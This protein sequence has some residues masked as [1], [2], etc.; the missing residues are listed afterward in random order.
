MASEGA[1]G[2]VVR[3]KVASGF[4]ADHFG[5][6]ALLPAD[7]RCPWHSY[8]DAFDVELPT[9]SHRLSLEH[10]NKSDKYATIT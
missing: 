1:S 3:G 9:Q 4:L 5:W 6:D 10:Q 2:I 8:P 7:G